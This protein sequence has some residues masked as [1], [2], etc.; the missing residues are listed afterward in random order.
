MKLI[1][2]ALALVAVAAAAPADVSVT[3]HEIK[4]LRSEYDQKPEG[5]YTFGFETENGI[6]R[7]ENGELK[8]VRDEENKPHTVITVRGS[9]SYNKEDGQPEIV[10]YYADENGYHAEGPSIPKVPGSN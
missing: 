6:V 10:Q 1:I 3:V 7:Q 5:S 4:T 9:Y 8:E 2:V